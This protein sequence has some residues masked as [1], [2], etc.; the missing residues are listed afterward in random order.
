M[1]SSHHHFRFR[2]RSQIRT[3]VR[4][5]ATTKVIA[6]HTVYR[7]EK[8]QSAYLPSLIKLESGELLTFP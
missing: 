5:R 4:E 6:M 2:A 7:Y 1:V 3:E 8:N